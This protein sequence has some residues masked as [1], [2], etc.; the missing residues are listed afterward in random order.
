ML[1]N[2]AFAVCTMIPAA[3]LSL[4]NAY[5]QSP[6]K[7]AVNAEC[8]QLK[9]SGA[10]YLWHCVFDDVGEQGAGKSKAGKPKNVGDLSAAEKTS[11]GYRGDSEADVSAAYKTGGSVGHHFAGV[12]SYATAADKAAK[13]PKK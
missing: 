12:P 8:V 10:N 9:K 1:R 6:T 5:F 4:D 11:M 2:I 13:K 7:P 3:S